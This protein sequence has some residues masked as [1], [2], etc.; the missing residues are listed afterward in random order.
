VKKSTIWAL[1]TMLASYIT[2]TP[3]SFVSFLDKDK[4]WF[5][6]VNGLS[7]E[8]LPINDSICSNLLIEKQSSLVVADLT[9]EARFAKKAFL[10]QHPEIKFYASVPL[11]SANDCII[12]SLGVLDTS[13]RSLDIQQMIGLITVAQQ[14]IYRLDLARMNH[15]Q[16]NLLIQYSKLSEMG[17][18]AATVAHEINNP[19]SILNSQVSIL[20]YKAETGTPIPKEEILEFSQ[21]FER[22]IQRVSKI[23]KGLKNISRNS[24]NDPFESTSIQSIFDDTLE[25]CRK[26]MIN[27]GV[28]FVNAAVPEL[29]IECRA[30]QISQV[31]LNLINNACDAIE[32]LPKKWIKLEVLD[33]KNSIQIS[34]T[35]SGAGIPEDIQAKMFSNFF[36]TKDVGKGTGIGLSVSS[37]IIKGHAGTLIIDSS[38]PNTK[39]VI[40][41]PKQQKQ[42]EQLASA[43]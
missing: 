1:I 7:I 30:A 38:C 4:Q 25:F 40:T 8:D 6:A 35:D 37:E 42:S 2:Q 19:L 5:K 11:R 29:K 10:K 43:A 12:G 9:K 21:S 23:V 3:Y 27:E 20:N 16:K 15:E 26:K 28:D 41:L 36:T 17:S 24:S 22:N 34:I 14:I 13:A 31:V 32:N 39:F 33:L 18:Y